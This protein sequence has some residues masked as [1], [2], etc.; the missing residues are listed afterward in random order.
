MISK[1]F[2]EIVILREIVGSQFVSHEE[3]IIRI[4]TVLKENVAKTSGLLE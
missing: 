3:E 4:D 1:I 2:E